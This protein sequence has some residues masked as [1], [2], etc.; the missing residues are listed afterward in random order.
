VDSGRRKDS[1]R[2][3]IFFSYDQMGVTD[4]FGDGEKKLEEGALVEV[5]NKTCVCSNL[6]CSQRRS[7]FFS[8]FF[9]CHH[10]LVGDPWGDRRFQAWKERLFGNQ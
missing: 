7:L 5:S 2:G 1:T 9:V 3:G 6:V 4:Y 8:F 10:A